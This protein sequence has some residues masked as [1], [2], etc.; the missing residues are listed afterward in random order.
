MAMHS[1][2]LSHLSGALMIYL[3]G[4]QVQPSNLWELEEICGLT[5]SIKC[6]Q[7]NVCAHRWYDSLFLNTTLWDQGI[8]LDCQN[9][10]FFFLEEENV[11]TP[12]HLTAGQATHWWCPSASTAV[13]TIVFFFF[14]DETKDFFFYCRHNINMLYIFL[15]STVSRDYYGGRQGPNNTIS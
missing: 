7:R 10:F 4:S 13:S 6:P 8:F 14:L 12:W 1:A 9:D 5:L 3:W 2:A 11:N 15:Q